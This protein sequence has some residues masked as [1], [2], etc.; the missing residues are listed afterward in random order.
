MKIV[1]FIIIAIIYLIGVKTVNYL[2]TSLP[3][4][5][6]KNPVKHYLILILMW[7]CTPLLLMLF[8]IKLMLKRK[9]N[10]KE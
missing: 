5:L 2:E 4:N 7:I 9:E 3:D 10:T 8:L 1:V 6:R